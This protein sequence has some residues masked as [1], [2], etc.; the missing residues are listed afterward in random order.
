MI[1]LE[2]LDRIKDSIKKYETI[3]FTNGF[4]YIGIGHY[5]RIINGGMSIDLFVNVASG[6]RIK[7]YCYLDYRNTDLNTILKDCVT[8]QSILANVGITLVRDRNYDNK[9][10]LI[11]YNI[12]IYHNSTDDT[13]DS[14][15]FS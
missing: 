7:V 5:Q 6:R 9:Y 12:K 15:K 4:H 11:P 8:L 13:I 10:Y 14:L 2:I 1:N 3:L